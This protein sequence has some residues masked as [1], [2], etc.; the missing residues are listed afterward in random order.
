MR[1]YPI[2]MPVRFILFFALACLIS[3]CTLAKSLGIRID[4]TIPVTDE[5]RRDAEAA[6]HLDEAMQGY[7]NGQF[8]DPVS[9]LSQLDQA[10]AINPDLA[11]AQLYKGL[12]HA[13]LDQ[14]QEALG[15][16]E[17]AS[18]L[19]PHNVKAVYLLGFTQ[20]K[21][22]M[23]GEA[24]ATM[25]RCIELDGSHVD[26]YVQRGYMRAQSGEYQAAVDDYS[27]AIAMAPNRFDAYFNKGLALFALKD[28]EQA[29]DDFTEAM[30]L[31]PNSARAFAARGECFLRLGQYARAR[32]DLSQAAR[33]DSS[34]RIMELIAQ[35]YAGEGDFS[36]AVETLNRAI[37]MT[38]AQGDEQQSRRLTELKDSLIRQVLKKTT[39]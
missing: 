37:A 33:T 8:L 7:H 16:L 22:G 11:D 23:T 24:E 13:Q 4:N 17:A 35:A 15:P 1:L 31:D 32:K 19:R 25:T 9:A 30:A 6:G 18:R 28:Y 21:L 12:A 27:Q 20:W 34:S 29:A 36:S 39:P 5:M 10:I 14:W 2:H 38:R 26:A 3:G